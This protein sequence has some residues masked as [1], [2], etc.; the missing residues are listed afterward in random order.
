MPLANDAAPATTRAANVGASLIELDV[1]APWEPPDPPPGRRGVPRWTVIALA[2]VTALVVL[3]ASAARPA[4]LQPVLR[5]DGVV[6]TMR[7]GADLLYVLSQP[8]DGRSEL[9]AYPLG[10]PGSATARPRWHLELGTSAVWP[11]AVEGD[12]VV[13]SV[14]HREGSGRQVGES[15]TQALDGRTG[16]VR[17][18]IPG[19]SLV[20]VLDELVVVREYRWSQYD[21]EGNLESSSGNGPV[22]LRA[23]D[24]DTGVAR[25]SRTVPAGTLMAEQRSPRTGA[26]TGRIA[27]YAPDGWLRVTDLRTGSEVSRSRLR[28]AAG[29]IRM[30]FTGDELTLVDPESPELS[31][32]SYDPATGRPRWESPAGGGPA[33]GCGA[34]VCRSS[35]LSAQDRYLVVTDPGSGA[36]RWRWPGG[37][38][39]VVL[40]DRVLATYGLELGPPGVRLFD[41]G[42]GRL[43]W[44]HPR[45]RLVDG[46]PGQRPLLGQNRGGDFTLARA[47]LD[48]DGIEVIGRA[49]GW[50]SSTDCWA[51]SGYVGCIGGSR[52]VVWRLP[53][54]RG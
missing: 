50:F 21:I 36:V 39:F 11:W 48:S 46:D 40:D 42:D 3:P 53:A 45:W 22:E 51:A 10:R 38:D 24:R 5:V 52:I 7:F 41:L 18:E 23:V 54:D 43:I 14:Q 28:R 4:T 25:W 13:L 34:Y 9:A 31:T 16:A 32:V 30:W 27:E 37:D 33:V 29:A 6:D 17:W 19:F 2:L 1:S 12:L 35:E 15:A 44:S 8:P 26:P 47:E 20:G 49:S